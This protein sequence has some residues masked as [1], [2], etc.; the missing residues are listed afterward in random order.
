MSFLLPL[1]PCLVGRFDR[2]PRGLPKIPEL[3]GARKVRDQLRLVL[4]AEGD[5]P[6]RA[7][8]WLEEQGAEEIEVDEDSSLE[9]RFVD[10]VSGLWKDGWS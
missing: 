1:L 10:L 2:T 9:S 4:W 6:E 8:E 3:L 7:R 5:A